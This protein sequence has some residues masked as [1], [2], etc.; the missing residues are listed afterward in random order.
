MKFVN[1]ALLVFCLICLFYPADA[2]AYLNP[3][4][5]SDFFQLIMGF[6]AGIFAGIK[7]FFEKI[8]SIFVKKKEKD[9][10]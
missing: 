4:S 2:Y 6:F 3:G 5:G 9:Y 10:E 8:K 7:A 1:I